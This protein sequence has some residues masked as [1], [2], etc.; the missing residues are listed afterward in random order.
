MRPNTENRAV[1]NSG[2]RNRRPIVVYGISPPQG[3]EVHTSAPWRGTS[4]GGGE[5]LRR[6]C[7]V[8]QTRRSLSRYPS[9]I[10]LQGKKAPYL[11]RRLLER[12][13]VV[14]RHESFGTA[15]RV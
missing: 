11:L 14:G 3:L 1:Q 5:G 4:S 8:T 7:V 10:V 13:E 6:I 2:T 15:C 9:L 12:P